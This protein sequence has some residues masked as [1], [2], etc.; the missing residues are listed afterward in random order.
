MK[1]Q[2]EIRGNENFKWRISHYGAQGGEMVDWLISVF[3]TYDFGLKSKNIESYESVKKYTSHVF[4]F[5]LKDQIKI[6]EFEE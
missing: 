3:V 1:F 2:F 5:L 6:I 4:L